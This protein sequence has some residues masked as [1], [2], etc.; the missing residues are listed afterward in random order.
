VSAPAQASTAEAMD[1]VF[2][3][4]GYLAAADPTAL[5]AQAQAD[6]LEGLE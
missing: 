6:C 4:L 3:G 5:P 2:T 1:M